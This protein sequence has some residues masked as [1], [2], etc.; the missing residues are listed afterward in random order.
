[1]TWSSG[2]GTSSLG[3]GGGGAGAASCGAMIRVEQLGQGPEIP[4]NEAG[5]VNRT[6]QWGQE[7]VRVSVAIGECSS[8]SEGYRHKIGASTIS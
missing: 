4:A 1:M 2:G 5:T 8:D 3:I 7:N 6:V